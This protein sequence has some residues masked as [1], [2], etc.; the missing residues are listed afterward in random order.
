VLAKLSKGGG[1][2][3]V[4]SL[5]QDDLQRRRAE[6]VKILCAAVG[7]PVEGDVSRIIAKVLSK[8]PT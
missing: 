8:E 2:D 6:S 5:Q 3:H 4:V 1:R 7:R